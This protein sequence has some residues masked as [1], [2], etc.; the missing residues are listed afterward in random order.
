MST[1]RHLPQCFS[2]AWISFCIPSRG[3]SKYCTFYNRWSRSKK[4]QIAHQYF[5]N[6]FDVCEIFLYGWM[7]FEI[8]F[9]G[10]SSEYMALYQMWNIMK[11]LFKDAVSTTPSWKLHLL[12]QF[13]LVVS[14]QLRLASA[15]GGNTIQFP[16]S[17]MDKPYKLQPTTETSSNG[18]VDISAGIANILRSQ[19][20]YG[21]TIIEF[22]MTVICL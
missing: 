22:S 5:C 13:I 21:K 9:F 3:R 20:P 6:S 17:P 1:S 19:P 12:T 8:L 4:T 11:M 14:I 2:I 15:S 7:G 18:L 10:T 16:T